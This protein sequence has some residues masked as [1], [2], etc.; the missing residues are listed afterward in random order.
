MIAPGPR[1][2]PKGI[3]MSDAEVVAE[4]LRASYAESW[5]AGRASVATFFAETVEV[6]HQPPLPTD[7]LTPG[8]EVGEASTAEFGAYKNMLTDFREE[9]TISVDGDRVICDVVLAGAMADGTEVRAPVKQVLTIKGDVATKNEVSLEPE[10]L[11]QLIEIVTAGGK[12][13]DLG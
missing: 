2:S 3:R 11:A 9:T 12:P 10:V 6:R 5:E 8:A 1:S 7:G 13:V 4:K